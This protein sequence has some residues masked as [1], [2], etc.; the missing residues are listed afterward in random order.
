MARPSGSKNRSTI[1]REEQA[2]AEIA[3]AIAKGK[4]AGK[5]DPRSAMEEIYRLYAEAEAF[6]RRHKKPLKVFGE[7]FDRRVKLAELLAKYQLP[8]IKAMDIPAPPPD[9]SEIEQEAKIVFGL[10]VFEGGRPVDPMQMLDE[11]DE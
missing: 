11:E 7:W 9:P 10:R 2:K 1:A 4:A 6:G 8:P 5:A 3:R